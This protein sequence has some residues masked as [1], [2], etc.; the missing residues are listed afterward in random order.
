MLKKRES[1]NTDLLLK[2]IESNICSLK[3]DKKIVFQTDITLTSVK[4][5][6]SILFRVLENLL[7]NAIR[8]MD[9][10]ITLKICQ[11]ETLFLLCVRDDGKGFSKKDLQ[12]A[13]N[14]FYGNEKGNDHFGIGLGVCKLLCEKH[15]GFLQIGNNKSGGAYVTAAIDVF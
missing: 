13:V 10:Q 1:Q 12:Q 6:K 14:M 15:G 11:R 9:K 2:E 7:E 4:I 3:G 5:D 8:Y